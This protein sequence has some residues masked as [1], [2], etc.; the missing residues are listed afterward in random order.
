MTAGLKAEFGPG[1]A[2]SVVV[3]ECGAAGLELTAVEWLDDSLG[4]CFKLIK[5]DNTNI[6]VLS[7][8][9]LE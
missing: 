8:L 5:E 2:V 3:V 1:S 6:V 9:N 7:I 4:E